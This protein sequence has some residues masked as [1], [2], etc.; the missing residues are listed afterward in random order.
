MHHYTPT[1]AAACPFEEAVGRA[2]SE[3]LN[4]QRAGWDT[5]VAAGRVFAAQRAQAAETRRRQ[6]AK[7]NALTPDEYHRI[8]TA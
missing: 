2:Q 6:E 4:C 7:L 3:L 1:E 8:Y 5:R